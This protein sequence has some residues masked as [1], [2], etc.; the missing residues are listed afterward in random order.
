MPDIFQQDVLD[1]RDLEQL[2]AVSPSDIRLAAMNLLSRRE[3]S[4]KELHQKLRKRFKDPDLVDQQVQRLAD[5]NLQSDERFAESFLRQRISRGQGPIRIRQEMR[6][7]GILDPDIS[8]T[9]EAGAP[10]WYAL[11]EATL[12]RKFGED[13]SANIKDQAKRS[14]FMQYRGFS[15][16][17]YKDLL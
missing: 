13:A 14:R 6:Q 17:H 10:D 1:E 9:L 7:R 4:A 3:H 2:T 11:A 5:E 16:E 15:S 12:H 8:A